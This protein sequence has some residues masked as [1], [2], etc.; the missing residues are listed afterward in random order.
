MS[1]DANNADRAPA[2]H[3]TRL[4]GVP[5]DADMR[6]ARRHQPFFA[7]TAA[8]VDPDIGACR[9]VV[10]NIAAAREL[11]VY[12]GRPLDTP[13]LLAAL[14]ALEQAKVPLRD[15]ALA[16]AVNVVVQAKIGLD[17][18]AAQSLLRRLVHIRPVRMPP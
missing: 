16:K 2:K 18:H 12:R 9:V 17:R 4:N 10:Q 11:K 14:E 7:I 1:A 13:R 15:H 3:G 6:E 8:E 5:S